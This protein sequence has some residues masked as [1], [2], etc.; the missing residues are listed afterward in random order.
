MR[1]S[2]VGWGVVRAHKANQVRQGGRREK[3]RSPLIGHGIHR[4]NREI[5]P[6]P[7]NGRHAPDA[8]SHPNPRLTLPPEDAPHPTCLAAVGA[9]F[10]SNPERTPTKCNIGWYSVA[11][12]KGTI[13]QAE[14]HFLHARL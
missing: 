8:K 9:V 11:G 5:G 13:A 4:G 10:T 14:L 12:L 6:F 3:D 1:L 2:L 7:R